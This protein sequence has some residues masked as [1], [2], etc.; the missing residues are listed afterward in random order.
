MQGLYR[1]SVV[2]VDNVG[3]VSK[4]VVC[5]SGVA[6]STAAVKV[7]NI[8]LPSLKCLSPGLGRAGSTAYYI[9]EHCARYTLSETPAS[10][11]LNVSPALEL[12]AIAPSFHRELEYIFNWHSIK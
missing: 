8:E 12:F 9:D 6:Y 10:C 3:H 11:T 7:A 5:S 4:P 2:A 1:A